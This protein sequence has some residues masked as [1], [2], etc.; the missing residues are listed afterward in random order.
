INKVALPKIGRPPTNGVK[1]R[2]QLEAAG[3]VDVQVVSFK[4]PYGPWPKD[5]RL[6]HIGNM[7]LLNME[8]AIEAYVMA[9]AVRILGMETEEAKKMCANGLKAIKNKNNH[10]YSF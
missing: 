2:A 7:V 1:M 10:I 8:T 5:R 9:A 3:F 6:K 4:H